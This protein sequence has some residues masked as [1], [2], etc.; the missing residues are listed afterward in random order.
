LVRATV[1]GNGCCP[2]RVAVKVRLCGVSLMLGPD[3]TVIC[4]RPEMPPMMAVTVTDADGA[5][6]VIC[7]T[8]PSDC[9]ET[10]DELLVLHVTGR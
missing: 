4:A 10:W 5:T 8:S 7:A 3:V 9:S 2:F 6:P 1:C